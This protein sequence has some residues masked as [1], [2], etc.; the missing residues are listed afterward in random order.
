MNPHSQETDKV[1]SPIGSGAKAVPSRGERNTLS[2]ESVDLVAPEGQPPE[3]VSLLDQGDTDQSVAWLDGLRYVMTFDES[4]LSTIDS[5]AADIATPTEVQPSALNDL[6][7]RANNDMLTAVANRSWFLRSADASRTS[8][9]NSRHSHA[10]MTVDL[11]GFKAV[12]DT[13]GHAAGDAV[14]VEIASRLK[15]LSR[16]GDVVG[17]LGGDEFA[18]WAER[19]RPV[20]VPGLA[21]R[22]LSIFAEPVVHQGVRI[23][24]SGSLGVMIVDERSS[25]TDVLAFADA[26]LYDAKRKGPESFCIFDEALQA[27]IDESHAREQEVTAAIEEDQFEFDVQPI[28]DLQNGTSV[29]V[30]L[31]ARWQNPRR[32][33]LMPGEFLPVIDSLNLFGQFDG[34]VLDKA[35]RNFSEWRATARP[36]RSIWVNISPAQ[37]EA[38]FPDYLAA[39][40]E[41]YGIRPSELVLELTED[42]EANTPGRMAVLDAVRKLGVEIAIDDF[43]TGYSQLAYLQDMPIDYV[44][45]DRSFISAFYTEPRR[46]AIAKSIILLAQAIGAKVVAEGVERQAELDLLI[47]LGCDYAQGF[48]LSRPGDPV[49]ILGI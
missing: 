42:V 30:E 4:S 17:R 45:L 48:L 40:M 47:E 15:A 2:V 39:V 35:A 29:G 10:L 41:Q 11:D 34:L 13:W 49:D 12:N 16:A 5:P 21:R 46:V 25:V 7:W 3:A 24:V 43:G 19:V 31:L 1:V 26:A 27:R 6:V 44:K 23:A 20:D 8:L 33:R 37:L 22:Y 36:P 14:L 9:A 28:V 18:V 32:G 38:A